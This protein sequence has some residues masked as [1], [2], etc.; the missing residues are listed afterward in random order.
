MKST[1]KHHA[2]RTANRQ[3]VAALVVG[4]LVAG[5]VATADIGEHHFWLLDSRFRASRARLDFLTRPGQPKT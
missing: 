4:G 2:A 3:G 1:A 5:T